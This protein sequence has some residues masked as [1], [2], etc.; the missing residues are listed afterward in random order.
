MKWKEK[1]DELHW[2]DT[3]RMGNDR[4]DGERETDGRLL[5][6]AWW[7]ML[8]FL[9]RT[10]GAWQQ[11]VT[12]VTF[13]VAGWDYDNI[14]NSVRFT[15]DEVLIGISNTLR[16]SFDTLKRQSWFPK[17]VSLAL[18]FIVSPV[19]A[20]NGF[21]YLQKSNDIPVDRKCTSTSLRTE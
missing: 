5:F 15:S 13:K 17:C 2:A 4:I 20:L 16:F 9:T 21:R 3:K 11:R 1:T 8:V 6:L 10:M 14:A 18:P 7:H 12:M 19:S